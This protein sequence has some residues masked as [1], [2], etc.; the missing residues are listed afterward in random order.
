MIRIL[1]A[2]AL[3][4]TSTVLAQSGDANVRAL[5]KEAMAV[6]A[7]TAPVVDGRLDDAIWQTARFFSDFVQKQPQEGAAP[8]ERTEIAFVYDDDA[9][10]VGARMHV[11]DPSTIQSFVTRRDNG[12]QSQHVWISLD[13]FLDGRTAYSFGV[14]ASGVRLDWYH[15]SDNEHDINDDWDPVWEA[16]ARVDSLG[17]TAEMRIPF[18]QLRFNDRPVQTWGLNVDRWIPE[19]NEDDFWIPVPTSVRAWSSYMGR[20]NG[21]E[22]IRPR[23][24]LELLPYPTGAVTVRDAPDPSNP[25]E[26]AASST[27]RLG[28]DLKMGLGPN[29]TLD[30]TVNPDFG[31]VEADP[32]VVNLSAFEVFFDERRPFFTEGSQLLSEGGAGGFFYSRRVGASPPGDPGGDYARVPNTSTILGAAKLT[33]RTGPGLSVAALG[34]VTARE[35]ARTYDL[36]S[37]RRI[38]V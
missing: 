36:A 22:G 28:G 12:S 17:W 34:A 7:A 16:R 33:G 37:E 32:A 27:A 5:R 25:F 11:A 38:S 4:L 8:T 14:T 9:L 23:R 31:Q 29:F 30:A 1:A 26:G 13:T 35:H 10:Y 24:R 3:G 18:S 20:L 15:A 2:L 19:K 21:I 6:R